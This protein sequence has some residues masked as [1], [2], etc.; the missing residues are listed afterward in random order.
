MGSLHVYATPVAALS[1]NARYAIVAGGVALIY[2]L[3]N[4]I[5]AGYGSGKGYAFFPLFVASVFVGF[6][7]VLLVV[8][9]AAGPRPTQR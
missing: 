9:I 7:I 5:V 8:T 3:V 4:A 6:P 2:L 1:M